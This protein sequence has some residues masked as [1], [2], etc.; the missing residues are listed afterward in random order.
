MVSGA[1]ASLVPVSDISTGSWTP[2][3]LWDK[4]D[5][6]VDTP[7]GTTISVASRNQVAKLG[8]L[9]SPVDVQTVT[10]VNLRVRTYSTAGA[11][12][13]LLVEMVSSDETTTYASF[14]PTMS[15][16]MTTYS[17]G[18]ITVSMTKAQIDDAILRIRSIDTAQPDPG[19]W[20]VDTLN[21][22]I[23]YTPSPCAAITVTTSDPAGQLWFNATV[24]PDGLAYTTQ[25]NVSASYQDATTPALRVTNDGSGSCDI[26]LRLMSDPGTGRSM[27]YNATNSA[28]WPGDT[29]K[30]V[31]LD[32]SSMTVC[33]AVASGGTCD[34]WLWVDYENALGGQTVVSLRVEST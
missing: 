17:S 7:D 11:A 33:S 4:I 8:Q 23:T 26:T 16:T 1:T 6:D 31:P 9:D 30:E 19:T 21:V 34:V 3:P 28:P 22:D 32:P 10:A 25:M 13:D 27:K 14:Q 5:E 18:D 24:E 12:H 15:T 29:T 2:L 20:E